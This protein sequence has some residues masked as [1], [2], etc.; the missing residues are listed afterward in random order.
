[1]RVGD[2][3]S[4]SSGLCCDTRKTKHDLALRACYGRVTFVVLCALRTCSLVEVLQDDELSL[5]PSVP[6]SLNQSC[7]VLISPRFVMG[8]IEFRP[9][10]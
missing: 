5:V 6:R 7:T 2:L 4:P 9:T 10:N 3:A 8:E 1:M